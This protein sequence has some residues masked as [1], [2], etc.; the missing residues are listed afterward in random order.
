[1]SAVHPELSINESTCEFFDDDEPIVGARVFLSHLVQRMMVPVEK[2][3][4]A[5]VSGVRLLTFETLLGMR[6]QVQSSVNGSDWTDYG[7]V[8]AADSF[9]YLIEIPVADSELQ[10]RITMID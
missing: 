10:F 9:D 5:A 4:L 3:E 2:P 7:E 6:Y 1:M 8:V